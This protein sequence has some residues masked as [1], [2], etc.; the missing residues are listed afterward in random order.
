MIDDDVSRL[1][2]KVRRN[3][4]RNG[5]A[6]L[7]AID[8]AFRIT[9]RGMASDQSLAHRAELVGVYTDAPARW[10][11]DDIRFALS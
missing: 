4:A 11:V 5:A 7:Y 1:A 6:C 10:I 9:G 3:A 2:D 8:G